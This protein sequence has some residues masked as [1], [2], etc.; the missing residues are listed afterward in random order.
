M[1]PEI[2]QALSQLNSGFGQ[3]VES[4][5]QLQGKGIVTGEYVHEQTVRISEICADMNIHII[6]RVNTFEVEDKDHFG[7]MRATIETQAKT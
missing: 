3:I 7:K 1:K 2:Y 4:L 5:K 6:D